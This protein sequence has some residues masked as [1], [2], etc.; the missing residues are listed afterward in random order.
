MTLIISKSFLYDLCLRKNFEVYFFVPFQYNI[1]WVLAL[2]IKVLS[3]ILTRGAE[4]IRTSQGK[5]S[6]SNKLL[7]YQER[8]FNQNLNLIRFDL[9]TNLLIF[10]F[11]LPTSIP[12][13]CLHHNYRLPGVL[14][15][16]LCW[17]RDNCKR[18][19]WNCNIF[20]CPGFMW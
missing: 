13:Y 3:S 1:E 11:L 16:P 6:P 8:S 14:A 12:V 4:S 19:L 20:L 5:F 15:L 2:V 17:G 10:F 7:W 18:R 9:E